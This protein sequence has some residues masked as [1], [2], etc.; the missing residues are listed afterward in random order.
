MRIGTSSVHQST[1]QMN[2]LDPRHINNNK[3][4]TQA[5]TPE[6]SFGEVFFN[7]INQVNKD[8][9]ISEQMQQDAILA[10]DSVNIAE[11]MI[12]TE[13]AR[14]SVSMLRS[15]TERVSRAYTDIVNIR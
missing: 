2:Q 1:L 13:K 9:N 6:Q 14:L 10:P 11:I 5:Q 12:A 15:V 4:K 7:A 3:P 8:Q